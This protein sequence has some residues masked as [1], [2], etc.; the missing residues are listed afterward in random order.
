MSDEDRFVRGSRPPDIGNP[1]D[2][3]VLDD[4][5]AKRALEWEADI[6]FMLGIPGC[7][8][9]LWAIIDRSG[10]LGDGYSES[11]ALMAMTEGARAFGVW[12]VKELT[13]VDP[14]AYPRLMLDASED[15][16]LE[17]LMQ[18]AQLESDRKRKE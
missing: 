4:L 12:L 14:A 3:Q 7:R 17:R 1:V 10:I 6:R 13:K 2:V 11:H 18:V 5:R 15:R 9:V 8:R 16:K